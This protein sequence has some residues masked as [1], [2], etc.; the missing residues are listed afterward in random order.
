MQIVC[1][2]KNHMRL[3]IRS[4]FF[5]FVIVFNSHVLK[6]FSVILQLLMLLPLAKQELPTSYLLSVVRVAQAL[7]W[8]SVL[9]TIC[10]LFVPFLL[11]IALSVLRKMLLM[12]LVSS[13]FSQPIEPLCIPAISIFVL[14]LVCSVVDMILR[15]SYYCSTDI[16]SLRFSPI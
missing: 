6:L 12:T 14:L 15:P 8:C 1:T 11:D 4:K 5:I 7:V 3:G 2:H 10:C 16:L 9:S 13:S